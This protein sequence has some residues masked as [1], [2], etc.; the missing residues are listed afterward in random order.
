M[1]KRE[2]S[3]VDWLKVRRHV[4]ESFV[5]IGN[6][7]SGRVRYMEPM[8]DLSFKDDVKED[9]AFKVSLTTRRYDIYVGTYDTY[10]EAGRVV[11]NIERTMRELQ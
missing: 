10:E 9:F 1:L 7:I 6:K 2:L 4:G 11:D 5:Y 3:T 8:I